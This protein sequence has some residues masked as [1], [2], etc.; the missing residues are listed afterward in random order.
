MLID[1]RASL[2]AAVGVM[3]SALR[4]NAAA[5]ATSWGI[6]RRR[7]LARSASGAVTT[8]AC[9]SLAACGRALIADWRA[10]R[11][12]RTIS[13]WRQCQPSVEPWLSLPELPAP[14]LLR[15]HCPISLADDECVGPGD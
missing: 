3:S 1:L 15:R 10:T 9:S 5:V 14:P 13:E 6:L 2:V 11:S 8:R 7:S 4:R 12:A